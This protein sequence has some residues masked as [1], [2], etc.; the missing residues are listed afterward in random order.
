MTSETK[1]RTIATL[2][3][4]SPLAWG[5]V[6]CG[7][8]SGETTETPAE[9]TT[10]TPTEGSGSEG[11]AGGGA[12]VAPPPGGDG[13]TE[14]GE[15]VIF[16]G[17]RRQ[18]SQRPAYDPAHLVREPNAPDPQGGDF[19][20]DEAVEGMTT[21]GELVAEIGTDFGTMFCDLYADR[22]P[23]TVANFIGLV[24]GTRPWWDM[25]AGQ[26][27]TRPYYRG[28][29]FHRVI[30]GYIVQ[31]GDY[32]ADGTG[33]VGYTMPYEPHET[34]RHD[35]AGMLALATLEGPNTGGGQIYITDGPAP[36]LDGSATVF[37]H[38]IPE[39]LVSQIARLPQSGSPDNRPLTPFHMTRVV[40]RRVPGGAD[41]AR[42]TPPR[43][44]PGEPETGRGASEDPSEARGRIRDLPRAG[45][46]HQH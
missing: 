23:R 29:T 44:P 20:L 38:C 6:A 18:G 24:R 10:S 11:T 7:N 45:D 14:D 37:G 15:R 46:P 1:R 33:A 4:G 42:A 28:L 19:T 30:P 3:L 16:A 26:W 17:T 35:R 34:L 39:D 8:E 12:P 27:V 5:L 22:A 21:D 36:Q 31:G 9:T 13:L 32:L 43:L 41:A 25:R 2:L 40:I